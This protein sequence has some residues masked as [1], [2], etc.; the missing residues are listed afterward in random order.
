MSTCLAHSWAAC[1]GVLAAGVAYTL[2]F[3]RLWEGRVSDTET[4]RAFRAAAATLAG[5]RTVPPARILATTAVSS[6]QQAASWGGFIW[7][8]AETPAPAAAAAS[9]RNTLCHE[10]EHLRRHHGTIVAGAF[11]VYVTGL[12]IC[13]FLGSASGFI[14]GG[15]AACAAFPA[16]SR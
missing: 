15:F 13:A 2:Q 6:G 16:L 3:R 10:R 4:V 11:G 8:A 5:G 9:I 1:F 7:V 12:L 14:L